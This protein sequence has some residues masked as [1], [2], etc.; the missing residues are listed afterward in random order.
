MNLFIT[1]GTGLIGSALCRELLRRNDRIT[2]LSRRPRK[3]EALLGEGI[4]IV[5]DLNEWPSDTAYDAVIN[6]AGEPIVGKR[7][8]GKRK[9]ILR[10]SRVAL[11]QT[12]VNRIAG[13]SS[14]PTVLLSASAVGYYGDTG[15]AEIGE[16]HALQAGTR[17][18]DFGA[19]LCHDWEACAQR[20]AESGVRVCLLRTGLVLSG[21]G[22]M[23]RQMLPAF[24]LGLGAKIGDGCQWMSWI[25][26]TDL[27]N[28][29]LHLL[30]N[31]GSR[32]A[33][34]LTAPAPA[35]NALFTR[36]LAEQ[37]HRPAILTAPAFGIRLA[38]G[39]AAH[40]L[41]GGQKAM[42]YRLLEE[43]FRFTYTELPNALR[44]LCGRGR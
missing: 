16:M 20:A 4:R 2:V 19:Q 22:G 37:L 13:A 39:E 7:W 18:T 9:N 40:L 3:A 14:K 24:R 36:T 38:L 23:L 5:S 27:V 17:G 25:H 8:S 21:E 6:L 11:T 32:G 30:D 33:Y 41:L 34:N 15:D 12:L 44:A 42:P 35:T 28:A 43:G 10:E 31:S 29:I 1:G 26:I